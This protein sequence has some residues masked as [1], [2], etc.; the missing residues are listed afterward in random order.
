MKYIFII[1]TRA[2]S[3]ADSLPMQLLLLIKYFCCSKVKCN[4]N[5]SGAHNKNRYS[6][7]FS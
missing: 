4:K 6:V 2:V 5:V 3:A 1:S 7:N